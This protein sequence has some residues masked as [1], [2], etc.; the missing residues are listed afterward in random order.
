[1]VKKVTLLS[2]AIPIFIEL[3]FFS[4][5]GIVDTFILSRVSDQAAGAVSACNQVI[6]F[7]NLIFNIICSGASVLI[8]QYIGAK[9]KEE[10]EKAI[11]GSYMILCVAGVI[12]SLLLFL[13][14]KPILAFIGVSGKLLSYAAVSMRIFGGLIFM[15]ALLN[16]STVTMRTHGYAKETLSITM[17]MNILNVIT[18][19]VLVF[20]FKMGIAGAATATTFSRGVA[21]L[22]AIG[23]VW[24]RILEPS[25]LQ[26]IK[27]FPKNIMKS[28][29]KVG[30]PSALEN[31]S[32]N[33][34]QIVVTSIILNNLGDTAYITRAYTLQIII[35]TLSFGLSIAQANQI[36]IGRLIGAGDTEGAYHT[37]LK[38]FRTAFFMAIGIGAILFVFGGTFIRIFTTSAEII[39]WGGITLMVDA[40]LEPGRTFNLVII[41]GLRG[42]GDVIFPVIMAIIFMWGVAVLGAYIF[43]V[44]LGF[45]LPGIWFAMGLDEWLRGLTMLFRW[46][47]RKWV[48]KSLIKPSP[49]SVVQAEEALI[50]EGDAL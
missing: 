11:M 35:I 34:S 18:V 40:F 36:L 30:L 41:N 29:I 16:M 49:E 23:F 47:S 46:K 45:G 28:L 43:G 26:Y 3:V 19:S 24:K 25:A 13:F 33:V 21:M 44:T 2:L 14:G 27:A 1:M 32:Y 8:S 10:T 39:K 12:C 4:L 48:S 7:T 22:F 6:G 37:C 42:A 20:G 15:Q 31:I 38:N 9:K 5:L 50:A 17:G